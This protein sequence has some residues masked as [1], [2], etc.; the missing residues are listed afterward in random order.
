M[1]NSILPQ[2]QLRLLLQ[3]IFS[4]LVLKVKRKGVGIDLANFDTTVSP[5]NDFS[6]M[7]MEIG[8]NLILF[9]LTR[10]VGELSVFSVITT[11]KPEGNSEA[12]ASKQGA[13]KG[14]PEQLVGD[15]LGQRHDTAKIESQ[16]AADQ[17]RNGKH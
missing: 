13:A 15:F 16:G 1:K 8:S 11:E 4:A 9:L 10:Y 3:A 2:R 12:A 6:T 7:P 5:S 14:S 17:S